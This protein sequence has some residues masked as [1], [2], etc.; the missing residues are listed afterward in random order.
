MGLH[1]IF[2]IELRK[3]GGLHS[4]DS[5]ADCKV[6]G[7]REPCCDQKGVTAIS[8]AEVEVLSDFQVAEMRCVALH[9]D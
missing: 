1:A 5:A 7:L 3:D 2:S 4:S 9:F 8:I 6:F